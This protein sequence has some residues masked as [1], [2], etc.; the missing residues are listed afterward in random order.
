LLAIRAAKSIASKLAPT[1]R[2]QKIY[3]PAESIEG[4][5]KLFLWPQITPF[6]QWQLGHGHAADADAF[7]VNHL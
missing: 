2:R 6:P 3:L 1:H 7:E 5:L 4:D